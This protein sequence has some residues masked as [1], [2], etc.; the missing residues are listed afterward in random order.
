MSTF[1]LQ[2]CRCATK[3]ISIYTMIFAGLRT[4]F[5][6][7]FHMTTIICLSFRD[8]TI[9][10]LYHFTWELFYHLFVSFYINYYLFV[11]L[12]FLLP[13]SSSIV[14]LTISSTIGIYM[15]MSLTHFQNHLS[16]WSCSRVYL[17]LL[18]VAVGCHFQRVWWQ[19]VFHWSEKGSIG[20]TLM[21]DLYSVW[22]SLVNLILYLYGNM[23]FILYFVTSIFGHFDFGLHVWL[24]ELWAIKLGRGNNAKEIVDWEKLNGWCVK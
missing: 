5:C 24:V 3:I 4:V 23:W 12:S 1:Q 22:L 7:S 16:C 15:I 21:S 11:S 6:L 13:I 20:F 10:C 19:R 9:I 18:F 17:N 14:L 8:R 2:L